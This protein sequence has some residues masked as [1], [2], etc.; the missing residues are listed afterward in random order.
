MLCIP[1]LN[2]KLD[3]KAT[4]FCKSCEDSEPLCE[5]CANQHTRQKFARDHDVCAN[6]T[7]F[8]STQ[9]KNGYLNIFY[10]ITLFL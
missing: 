10:H 1:C 7:E 9:P 4:H 8:S 5:S 6:M 2:D 3:V